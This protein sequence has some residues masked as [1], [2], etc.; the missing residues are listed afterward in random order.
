MWFTVVLTESTAQGVNTVH[1]CAA[2][3]ANNNSAGANG[4]YAESVFGI[5]II[6]HIA[7]MNISAV[8]ALT[9]GMID[10]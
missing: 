4:F 9:K 3:I 8:F 5:V 10:P 2:D 1:S 6:N 7:C